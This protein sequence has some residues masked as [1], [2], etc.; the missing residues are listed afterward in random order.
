MNKK[1]IEIDPI[2]LSDVTGVDKQVLLN[3][4]TK[5]LTLQYPNIQTKKWKVIKDE[6]FWIIKVE[7]PEETTFTNV[8]IHFIEQINE[9]QITTIEIKHKKGKMILYCHVRAFDCITSITTYETTI[10]QKRIDYNL[11]VGNK[12]KRITIEET[13]KK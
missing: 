1:V 12:R 5:I 13:I 4:A 2:P 8:Q 3:I 7:F 11:L 10:I 6:G 9:S